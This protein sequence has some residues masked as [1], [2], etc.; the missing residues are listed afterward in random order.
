M[1]PQGAGA[2]VR[3]GPGAGRGPATVSG[4]RADPGAT[5]VAGRARVAV[6]PPQSGPGRLDDRR[7]AVAGYG[8]DRLDGRGAVDGAS[9]QPGRAGPAAGRADTI[10][11]ADRAGFDG[12]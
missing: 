8:D 7:G 4:R 5:D 12:R 10:G 11:H 3:L 6:V 2:T 1:P 9:R